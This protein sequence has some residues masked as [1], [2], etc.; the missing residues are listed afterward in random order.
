[1]LTNRPHHKPAGVQTAVLHI[2]RQPR[3]ACGAI[4]DSQLA[5]DANRKPGKQTSHHNIDQTPRRKH[6]Q[7]PHP[8][9]KYGDSFGVSSDK[10]H[11]LSRQFKM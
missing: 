8:Q 4:G 5:I 9:A 7:H 1:M 11:L 6:G 3:Q 2:E 10:H